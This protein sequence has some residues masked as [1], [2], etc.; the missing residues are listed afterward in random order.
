M[1]KRQTPDELAARVK[2]IEEACV[3]ANVTS[4]N[5][6]AAAIVADAIDGVRDMLDDNA[7]EASSAF[8]AMGTQLE[9]CARMLDRIDDRLIEIAKEVGRG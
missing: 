4:W 9:A 7:I 6:I 8:E 1:A 2:A 5:Y 3:A